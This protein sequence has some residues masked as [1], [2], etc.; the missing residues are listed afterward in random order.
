MDA[1]ERRERAEVG[2]LGPIPADPRER[3]MWAMERRGAIV[4]LAG[5]ADWDAALLK[6][7]TLESRPSGRTDAR[8][9]C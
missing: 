5:L 9:S 8:P 1:H 7:A 2:E 6:R 4:L 3:E